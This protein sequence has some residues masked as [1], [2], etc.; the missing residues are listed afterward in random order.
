MDEKILATDYREWILSHELKDGKFELDGDNI[1]IKTSYAEGIVRFHEITLAGREIVV[2]E[3]IVTNLADDENK[4]YLH[5]ELKDLAHAKKLFAD[6][7]DVLF[8]LKNQQ[9]IKILLCCTSGLTTSFFKDKLNEATNLLEL[10]L[11]FNAVDFSQLYKVGF[12]YS[13]ILLAPQIAFRFEETR[14]VFHDKIVLK[15]PPKLFARYDVSGMIKLLQSEIENRKST[16]EERAIAKAVGEIK[17]DK[18]ILSIAV[19]P[20]G[21]RTR[22]AYRIYENGIPILED[23]IIKGELNVVRDLEDIMDTIAWQN[24]SYDAIGIAISGTVRNGHLEIAKYIDSRINLKA[25]LEDLYEVPV[26]ITNNLRG[27]I[28]GFYSQQEKYRNIV[29]LHF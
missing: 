29:F 24:D 22:I 16:A 25:Y 18:K 2:I 6:M 12:D 26:V 28:L 8:E 5:F 20:A 13:V 27:A 1:E 21:K 15:V 7:L 23:M 4:Y 14:E 11:E 17:N 10:D 19:M 9:K 3:Q